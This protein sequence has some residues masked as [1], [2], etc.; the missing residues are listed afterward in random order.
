MRKRIGTVL[1]VIAGLF[2]C[3]A[4]LGRYIVLPGYIETLETGQAGVSHAVQ[5]VEGWKVARYLLWAYSFKLGVLFLMTGAFLQ[6]S[7]EPARF[8]LFAAAG[9]AYIVFA[10]IPLPAAESIVFG[11]AGVIMTVLIILIV[12][13]WA[14]KRDQAPAAL[15]GAADYRM[16]G[17]FFFAMATYTLCSLMGVKT[18]A[19][20][21]EKMI[22]YGLQAEAASF[23]LHLLIELVLG[24]VFTYLAARKS[25]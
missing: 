8:R 20:Q 25:S 15:A 10:Y 7:M 23:A 2:F 1:I 6:T 18:F 19:L 11:G 9:L 4:I 5:N 22:R 17:Y 16:A 12:L 3:N 14:R 21:P 24:W 13:S